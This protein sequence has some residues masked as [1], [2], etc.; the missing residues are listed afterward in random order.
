MSAETYAI[1]YHAKT[2]Q[3]LQIDGNI[4]TTSDIFQKKNHLLRAD[5][6]YGLKRTSY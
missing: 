2:M 1:K 5:A 4:N 3:L 6:L